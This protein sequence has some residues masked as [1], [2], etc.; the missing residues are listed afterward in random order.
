MPE[1]T[2]AFDPRLMSGPGSEDFSL[3]HLQHYVASWQNPPMPWSRYRHPYNWPLFRPRNSIAKDILNFAGKVV[4]EI[5]GAEWRWPAKLVFP[6]FWR[7]MDF[8][9]YMFSVKNFMKGFSDKKWS[10]MVVG[11]RWFPE[12]TYARFLDFF[13]S[14]YVHLHTIWLTYHLGVRTFSIK[15]P[16][17]IKPLDMVILVVLTIGV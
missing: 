6:K 15:F 1:C 13:F 5:S 3:V 2:S 9:Y 12:S 10:N 17:P 8:I 4:Q 14:P 11:R 16:P 7:H